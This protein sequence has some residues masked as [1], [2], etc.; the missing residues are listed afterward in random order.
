MIKKDG[1]SRYNFLTTAVWENEEAFEDA[2]R[3][4]AIEFQKRGFNRKDKNLEDCECT[5]DIP[6]ISLLSSAAIFR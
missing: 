6:K 2:K 1:E 3:A 5:V 4:I